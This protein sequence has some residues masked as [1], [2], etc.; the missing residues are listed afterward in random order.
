MGVAK[1]RIIRKSG[2]GFI[3]AAESPEFLLFIFKKSVAKL[4]V[5]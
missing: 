5:N 2:K 3:N 4:E 1:W